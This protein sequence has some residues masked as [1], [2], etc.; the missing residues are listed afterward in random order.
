MKNGEILTTYETLQRISENRELKFNVV[1]GYLLAKNKEKLRQE[2]VL[3]YDQRKQI[4]LEHGKIDEDVIRVPTEYISETN[5][6]INQL[7]EIENNVELTKIPIDVFEECK[8]S[9][10]DIE[11]LS[12]IIAP[13]EVSG[14]PIVD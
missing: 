10:E 13:F 14:P 11:G 5:E 2:A 1:A 12:A 8:M 3:I 7:M 9:M 4:I 6:K